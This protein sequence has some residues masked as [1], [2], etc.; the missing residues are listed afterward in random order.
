MPQETSHSYP[1][2]ETPLAPDTEGLHRIA[3]ID[4]GYHVA[5]IVF[6]HGLGGGSHNT[7]TP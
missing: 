6:V 7:W 2:G 3:N 4:R 5:D 1:D